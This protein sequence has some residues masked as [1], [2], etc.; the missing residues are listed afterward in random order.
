MPWI[1]AQSQHLLDHL[2]RFYLEQGNHI[3]L[4]APPMEPLIFNNQHPNFS[5][6]Q[7]IKHCNEKS[8]IYSSRIFPKWIESRM[9]NSI[10]T[11]DCEV[12]LFQ[13]TSIYRGST[14]DCLPEGGLHDFFC[15]P[16]IHA[17]RNR[18]PLGDA[19][20]D[21]VVRGQ[22][23]RHDATWVWS[24]A[25]PMT[26]LLIFIG[27]TYSLQYIK[28]MNYARTC[29]GYLRGYIPQNM[30]FHAAVP[31]GTYPLL[32]GRG[33]GLDM[34]KHTTTRISEATITIVT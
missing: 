15:Q 30:I 13:E 2:H 10:R 11:D 19:V 4:P 5:G 12:P 8:T 7:T 34:G 28:S 14:H 29:K 6:N 32:V 26:R 1:S 22:G 27:G 31:P 3:P 20:M 21:C 9:E 17:P 16:M 25:F 33:W 23:K 24:L 18:P